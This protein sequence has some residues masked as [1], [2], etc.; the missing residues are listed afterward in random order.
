MTRITE[1]HKRWQDDPAYRDA[2]A[3]QDEEFAVAAALIAAR[4]R[5]GLSQAEVAVRMGTTQSAVARMEGG[6]PTSVLTLRKYARAT[7]SR[8]KVSLE[9]C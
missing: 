7:G 6:S 1:L 4:K 8:L 5:A 2:Y 9:A 3:E